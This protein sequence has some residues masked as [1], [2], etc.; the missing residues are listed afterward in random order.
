MAILLMAIDEQAGDHVR[1]AIDS[2]DSTKPVGL[3]E[4]VFGADQDRPI[5]T[6]GLELA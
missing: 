3:G 5:R 6:L 2:A 4:F 1:T